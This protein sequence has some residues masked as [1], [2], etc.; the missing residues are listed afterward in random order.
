ML[1]A[2]EDGQIT[3]LAVYDLDRL[4]RQPRDLERFFDVCDRAGVKDLASVAGD[5]DLATSDGRLLARI[6]GAVAAKSS[7]DTSR[8]IKRKLDEV[9]ADGRKHGGGRRFGYTPDGMEVVPQEATLIRSA[10]DA[11][12]AGSTLSD[13]ARRWNAGGVATPQKAGAMWSGVTVRQ[14]LT[15]AHQAGLRRHRGE[16]IGNGVWPSIFTRAEH[17]RIV[18]LLADRAVAF[19]PPRSS[20]LTGLV[21][22]GKCGQKMTRNGGQ[23]NGSRGRVGTWRCAKRPGYV[24]CGQMSVSAGPFEELIR[25]AVLVALDGPSL[26]GVLSGASAKQDDAA[27][28][29]LV[30]I[31]S[32]ML[33]LAESFADGDIGKAEWLRARRRL[34]DRAAD[35]R[36]ALHRRE[37]SAVLVAFRKPGALRA[38]W[39]ELG[40]SRQH[41]IIGAV[42][43]SIT[44]NRAGRRGPV[45]DPGRVEMTWRV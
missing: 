16:I 34:E 31:E 26:V 29:E 12:L 36:S 40:Q 14:V 17:E 42:V 4:H 39:P 43:E 37:R 21:R 32:R 23:P 9:A 30:E 20:L 24:N 5:V 33:Q 45:F 10:A 22:C 19:D 44:V 25:E 38:A 7:D 27:A 11:V 1:G 28:A 18:A 8:R 41:A 15:G 3:A 2:L 6:M 35:A 13:V